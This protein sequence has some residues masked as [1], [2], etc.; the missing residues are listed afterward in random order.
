MTEEN[1]VTVS[2]LLPDSFSRLAQTMQDKV[3]KDD[4]GSVSM[5]GFA[6]NFAASET[7]TEIR[8]ALDCDV[9]ALVARGWCF[10]SELSKYKD[11]AKYP[12]GTKSVVYLGEHALTTEVHPV[13]ALSIGPIRCRPI[14]FTVEL[15]ANFLTAA[16]LIVNGSIVGLDSGDC[17]VSAQ[18]KYGEI[19]LHDEVKSRHVPLPGRITFKSPLAIS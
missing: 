9:F 6:W 17:F 18:L 1:G 11:E 2:E 15:K 4:G 10:A 8:N 14:R 5:P 13:L 3:S 7:T 16:L 19:S 12:A